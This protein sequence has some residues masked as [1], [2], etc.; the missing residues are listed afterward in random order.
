MKRLEIDKFSRFNEADVK[1]LSPPLSSFC[2]L[3]PNSVYD[4][5][6]PLFLVIRTEQSI[7]YEVFAELNGRSGYRTSTII[8]WLESYF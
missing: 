5:S 8:I 3:K 1:A 6:F 7:I 2:S 4:M